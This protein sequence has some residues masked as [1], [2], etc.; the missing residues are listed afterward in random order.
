MK[1][2]L[3]YEV[4]LNCI[5]IE[6]NVRDCFLFWC[7]KTYNIRK[8]I[9]NLFPNLILNNYVGSNKLLQ[10]NSSDVLLISK[11]IINLYEYDTEAKLGKLLGYLSADDYNKLDRSKQIYDYV[12]V[13]NINNMEIHLFNEL[14]QNKL[15]YEEIRNKIEQAFKKNKLSAIVT[16]INI[17]ERIIFLSN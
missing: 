14:S 13:A 5:L 7:K 6:E 10:L 3:E 4:L 15:Y 11:R 9:N 8:Y 1:K 16:N 2:R 17:K 12:L